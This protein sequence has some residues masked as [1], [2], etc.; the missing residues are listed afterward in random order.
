MSIK[1]ENNGRYNLPQ[2]PPHADLF[3]ARRMISA[4]AS[5]AVCLSLSEWN[6]TA[7][8]KKP[9]NFFPKRPILGIKSQR[10]LPMTGIARTDAYPSAVE[11][12]TQRN[13]AA[14][15]KKQTLQESLLADIGRTDP[16]KA[17]DLKKKMEDTQ[18]VVDQLKTGRMNTL[19]SRK[20]EAVEKVKRIKQEIQMLKAMGGDPRALARRIAQL[21][22]ELAQ[23]AREYVSASADIASS[24]KDGTIAAGS[25]S[26]AG[27]V[28]VL[29]GTE[30]AAGVMADAA[31]LPFA[32][33]ETEAAAPDTAAK[34]DEKR[35]GD[36]TGTE[37]SVPANQKLEEGL[38]QYQEAQRQKLSD[39][40]ERIRGEIVQQT[41]DAEADRKFAQD[42]RSAAALL[43]ALAEQ[44]KRRLHQAGD[45]T[46]GFEFNEIDKA[47]NDAEKS[48]SA[49]RAST[50]TATIAAV[51]A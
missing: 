46:V 4:A 16:E 50:M 3:P 44:Q 39:E 24:Q 27:T 40:V 32:S 28:A 10:E 15:R 37:A 48:V 51:T 17:D 43:K 13:A 36:S 12:L 34:Q 23:A 20:A 35:D 22:R 29:S 33:T 5:S 19:K 30:G 47:L 41:V 42:V 45:D 6:D 38:R 18:Q 26:A 8:R 14:G 7:A 21:S 2:T 11:I 25:V 31:V 1:I 9:L 49:I